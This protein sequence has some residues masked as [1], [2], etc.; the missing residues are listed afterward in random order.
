M[1]EIER[2]RDEL[3]REIRRPSTFVFPTAPPTRPILGQSYWDEAGG[4]FYIYH[5]SGWESYSKDV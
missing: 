5:P 2:L 1:T 4:K 3:L